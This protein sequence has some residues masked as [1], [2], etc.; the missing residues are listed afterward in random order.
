M[1]LSISTIGKNFFDWLRFI[2]SKKGIP[3][4]KGTLAYVIAYILAFINPFTELIAAPPQVS[5]LMIIVV[6][7][8]AGA[9]V[10]ICMDGM[11]WIIFGIMLGALCAYI[12]SYLAGALVAQGIVYFILVYIFSYAK[13]VSLKYLA[14]TL[15]GIVWCVSGVAASLQNNNQPNIPFIVGTIQA[16]FWGSAIVFFVNLFVFPVSCETVLR[17]TMV[18]ALG[19]MDTLSRL[20]LQAYAFDLTEADAILRTQLVGQLRRE[21]DVIEQMLAGTY[22]EISWSKW[23][24][25]D[26]TG[27]TKVIRKLHETLMSI[28]ADYAAAEKAGCLREIRDRFLQNTVPDMK[29]VSTGRDLRSS[30]KD[31][32]INVRAAIS[33][34]ISELLL[35]LDPTFQSLKTQDITNPL[36]LERQN[37]ADQT[38]PD[39]QN[40]EIIRAFKQ[41]FAE[42]IDKHDLAATATS[43]ATILSPSSDM[44]GTV[45][46]S[47][48]DTPVAIRALHE[49]VNR[50]TSP[51]LDIVGHLLLSGGFDA[52]DRPLVLNAPLAS[53]AH[54]FG[55]ESSP[56]VVGS[57]EAPFPYTL[58]LGSIAPSVNSDDTEK[59]GEEL[60]LVDSA[61]DRVG[62]ALVRMYSLMFAVHRLSGEVQELYEAVLSSD[63]RRRRLHLH[64]YQHLVSRTRTKGHSSTVPL[65]EAAQSIGAQSASLPKRRFWDWLLIAEQSLLGP[66]NV[67]AFKLTLAIEIL[68]ILLWAPVVRTWFLSYGLPITVVTVVLL[69]TPTFGETYIWTA[70]QLG[71]VLGYI[72]AL[73]LLEIFRNVG[74]YAY[75]PYGI[76]CIIGVWTVPLMYI[77]HEVPIG[78]PFGLLALVFGAIYMC[79]NYVNVVILGAPY[80]TPSYSAAKALTTIAVGIALGVVFQFLILRNPA[81][82]TL[83]KGLIS[84]L[85]NNRIYLSVL[86][87]YFR[88]LQTPETSLSVPPAA[89]HA[90]ELELER[91]EAGI[92]G[93]IGNIAPMIGNVFGE[94]YWDAPFGA[95][96]AKK[97]LEANEILLDRLKDARSAMRGQPFDPYLAQNFVWVL[98]P[99]R[100]QWNVTVRMALYLSAASLSAQTPLPAD[101]LRVPWK[102][103]NDMVQDSLS[104]SASLGKSD[105]GRAALKTQD[106]ARFW[107]FLL[108]ISAATE[109]VRAIEEA[110]AAIYG[111]DETIY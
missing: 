23:S 101:M 76:V 49:N 78:F 11:I 22:F 75:N 57:S 91:R 47:F 111:T 53:I 3:T 71:G 62:Q 50:W 14:F 29:R 32:L 74:G 48:A 64:C 58:R 37:M 12:L 13:A 77:M 82:R 65:T 56:G 44:T 106:F 108:V 61:T 18:S 96:A 86:H 5:G 103:V 4:W 55:Q 89:Y 92:R 40:E 21:T 94:P 34:T 42:E 70:Q 2:F 69:V 100:R 38:G 27:Q 99:Y 85:H 1:V 83:R 52:K 20:L 79:N 67:Y 107:Y 31:R 104:L 95:D 72:T 30:C 41:R 45:K 28:N 59:D 109:Q 35:A 105:E 84:L 93:Q 60:S 36:D 87:A 10:G 54:T 73:I 88:F 6:L 19:H 16:Y 51:Q 81:R 97:V 33:L 17:N 102:F 24:M 63:G 68:T 26:I 43:S 80:D 39:I 90:V 8:V 46:S 66:R 9:P 98:A 15:L 7:A 110:C 25:G